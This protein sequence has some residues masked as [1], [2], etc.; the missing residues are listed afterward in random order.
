MW[1]RVMLR[2]R[3]ILA[4]LACAVSMVSVSADN[5]INNL[6][7]DLPLVDIEEVSEDKFEICYQIVGEP[8]IYCFIKDEE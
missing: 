4:A 5:A 8:E 2:S 7:E 3:V 1:G 6:P